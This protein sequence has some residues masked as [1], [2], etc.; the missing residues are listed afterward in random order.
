MD[1]PSIIGYSLSAFA[2]IALTRAYVAY[3]CDKFIMD[4]DKHVNNTYKAYVVFDIDNTPIFYT[5]SP[6]EEKAWDTFRIIN[7]NGGT[8][9]W[10]TVS[11]DVKL[12]SKI[13]DAV[14]KLFVQ[15]CIDKGYKVKLVTFTI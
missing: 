1:W 8:A 11:V 10:S 5:T 2:G 14:N 13:N 4:F 9:L 12:A 15:I 6:T 3:R 7:D